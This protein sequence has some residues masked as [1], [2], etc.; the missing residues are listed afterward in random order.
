[1]P[2]KRGLSRLPDFRP[3]VR[4]NCAQPTWNRPLGFID[5]GQF[6]NSSVPQTSGWAGESELLG[7]R[8]IY[9]TIRLQ[10]MHGKIHIYSQLAADC[11]LVVLD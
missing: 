10:P 4:V 6:T 7:F 11:R 2:G 8:P 9:L 5:S 1:M 3:A